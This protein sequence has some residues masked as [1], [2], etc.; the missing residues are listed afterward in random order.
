MIDTDKASDMSEE[1]IWCNS[2]KIN[3]PNTDL[4]FA[5]DEIQKRKSLPFPAASE[6][7]Y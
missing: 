2:S 7:F 3:Q 6:A 5:R 1:E 4:E